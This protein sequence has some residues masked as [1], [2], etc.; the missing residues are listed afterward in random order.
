MIR[1]NRKNTRAYMTDFHIIMTSQTSS[2]NI[3][4]KISIQLIIPVTNR[5]QQ[6]ILER[7][8]PEYSKSKKVAKAVNQSRTR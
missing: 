2:L 3:A 6:K 7:N 5:R 4:I 8:Y 1:H